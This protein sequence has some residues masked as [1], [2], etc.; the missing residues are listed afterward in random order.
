MFFTKFLH[1]ANFDWSKSVGGEIPSSKVGRKKI[2]TE[3]SHYDQGISRIRIKDGGA[4]DPDRNLIALTPPKKGKGCVRVEEGCISIQNELGEVVLKSPEEGFF[5]AAEEAHLFQFAVPESAMYY[6]MGGKWFKRFELSGIRTKNYNTDVWSDFHFAQWNEH[7]VDPSYFA[8]PYVAVRTDKGYVG[9]LLHNP[10]VTTIQTPGHD[11]ARVFVNWQRT[12]PHLLIGA[13]NGSPD[14][15][16]I[17]AP[18]LAELTRRLQKLV[19]VTPRPPLWSLGFHQSRWGYGGENDLLKLSRRFE[20][21]S[22]PCSALWLDLDYMDGYRI[23]TVAENQFPNGVQTVTDRLALEGRR[24]VPIIDPGVKKEVGYAVFDDGMEKGAFCKNNLGKPYVGLVWP[25]ETVFPDL[26]SEKGRNWFAGYAKG[27][28]DLGFT[29]AWVDMNDPST[30]PVDPT[31]MLFQDGAEPHD[32]HR[33]QYALGMQMATI[34]GFLKSEPKE[35]PFLLSRSGFV[36]SSRYSAIWHGDNVS[37]EA[38]LQLSIPI[39]IGMS[40]S[41]LPFNGPDI[42][43]FGGGAT[44]ELMAR[45]VQ[46]NFLFPFFR[47]HSTDSSPMEEPWRYSGTA[48]RSIYHFIRLRY[49]LLPYLYQLFIRQ[50]NSGDPVVRPVLYEFEEASAYFTSDAFMVGHA[51]LQAPILSESES[52]RDVVLPGSESWWDWQRGKWIAPGLRTVRA[53]LTH[54]PIFQ[55]ANSIVPMLL[56]PPT[57]P[58]VDMRSV[59]FLAAIPDTGGSMQADYIADDGLSFDYR[60]GQESALS[61]QIDADEQNVSIKVAQTKNGYGPL[62]A[63]VWCTRPGI[64]TVNGQIAE[65]EAIQIRLAGGKVTVYR[66]KL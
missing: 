30:G 12:W 24:M 63:E 17:S 41:G 18:S 37:N 23:F 49:Q 64:F 4:W 39:A 43:G 46:A 54:T 59:A 35:R 50:E 20:K 60:S 32:R 48:K 61:L 66:V 15:W 31:G 1:P 22:L 19:G 28:R 36:G 11:R 53:N 2:T 47:N 27:F 25:G 10:G 65:S 56:E 14:L 9:L 51:L 33:N 55:R 13:E 57:K 21:E 26:I 3:I 8:S 40:I 5:G 62:A 29:A 45:W 16:V 52:K 34:E 38:H 7:E 6:G 44:N 58:D 42:G